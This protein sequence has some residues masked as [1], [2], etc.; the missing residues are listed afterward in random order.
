MRPKHTL[1]A[2]FTSIFS[3]VVVAGSLLGLRPP[4]PARMVT[5]LALVR[6]LEP[7]T[8]L[9]DEMLTTVSFPEDHLPAGVGTDR[10]QFVGRVVGRALQSRRLLYP[11]DLLSEASPLTLQARIPTGMRAYTIP[12]NSASAGLAGF[13]VPGSRVDVLS[14]PHANRNELPGES[15]VVVENV[16]ILAVDNAR[17]AEDV[18]TNPKHLTLLVSQQQARR[19]DQAQI[20]GPL[21]FSLRNEADQTAAEVEEPAQ[22]EPEPDRRP[23][24]KVP[25]TIVR[26]NEYSTVVTKSRS[27]HPKPARSEEAPKIGKLRITQ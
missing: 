10:S 3:L 6:D 2:V 26:H 17:T 27:S 13:A 12:L 11:A 19:V 9:S 14:S 4:T 22:M 23:A 7:G 1:L 24:R 8:V 5:A 15:E 20:H 16:Q 18:P 25:I 21:R